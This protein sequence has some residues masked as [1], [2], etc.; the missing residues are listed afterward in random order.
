M[1]DFKLLID[2][3]LV[4]GASTMDVIN[5]ANE[6]VIA[7]SPRANRD[8]LNAAVAAANRAFP[9]WSQMPLK[10]RRAYILRF[11]DALE[12]QSGDLARQLTQ[13]QG[14]P[15]SESEIEIE[16]SLLFLRNIAAY[17][18]PSRIIEDNAERRVEM[19]RRPLG[20]VA[21]II[22]W[23]FPLLIACYKT[24]MALLPGNTMII[25][26]APTTPLTTLMAGA[27]MAEIFPAGV[28]NI[29]TD[30]NDLGTAITAHPDIAKVSFTGSTA[31]GKKIMASVADTL[32]RLTLELGGND[33]AIV[34]SDVDLKQTAAGIF[35]GAF[36]NAGQICIAI[37]R[38]YAHESIYDALCDELARLADEAVVDDGMRQGTRIG[39]LQN[40]VQYD[41]VKAY[42]DIAKQDGKVISGGDV[43]EGKGYFIRPTIVR[44]IGQES[45]LVRE[46]Q[47][48]PILPIIRF[49]ETDAVIEQAN[50]TEYG[51]AGS[52]WSG[53]RDVAYGLARRMDSG[54]IWIN[55]HLD[56]G[57]NIP[58]AGAKESGI[59]VEWG[60]EGL[61]EFTQIQIINEAR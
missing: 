32:K 58:F 33:A 55:K 5:P 8:Q 41:K 48:G 7:E 24:V 52:V 38:V 16:A 23:N 15:L 2:G 46:E 59:G 31:T 14:K 6:E 39:P 10:E 3:A 60:E 54:T 12:A 57:P 9:A 13:E 40:K 21:G 29:I 20:V 18:L 22:P 35:D 61:H 19:L 1:S 56:F 45:R 37:K 50:G 47:F 25:K 26:P 30:A 27:I 53:D 17:D 51:L 43:R 42:L 4:D 49:S 28:V 34:L 44:D 36:T 11:A